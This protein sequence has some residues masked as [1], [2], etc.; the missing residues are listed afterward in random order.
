MNNPY[1][2]LGLRPGASEEE[3]KKAYRTLSRKYHP[4]ANINNPN[5]EQ[6]EAKFKE[7]QQAYQ[8]IMDGNTN[9]YSYGYGSDP[10][11]RARNFGG[12]TSKEES[13]LGA[14]QNFI[15]NGMWQE[16]L[17]TLA[18]IEERSGRWY[19]LSATANMGAG[20]QA[21]AMEHINKAIQLEPNNLEYRRMQSKMQGGGD[22]YTSR[23]A[24]YEMPNV[25]GNGCCT[26][27]CLL[28]ML[29]RLFRSM[30]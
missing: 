5:K 25:K 3:V 16:A 13:R 4:D 11:N 30:I 26:S 7:V 2:T 23:S 18:D 28:N 1:E 19:Y 8:A 12:G 27:L 15:M 10:F 20:N 22:W 9:S 6:A 14:A 21:T 24:T 29:C 17:R